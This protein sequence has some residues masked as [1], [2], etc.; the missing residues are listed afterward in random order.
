MGNAFLVAGLL[1]GLG[2]ESLER[3]HIFDSSDE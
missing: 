3:F 2:V 1:R